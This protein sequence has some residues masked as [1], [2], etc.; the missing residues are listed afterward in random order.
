MIGHHLKG[1][2]ITL[3]SRIPKDKCISF[4]FLPPFCLNAEHSFEDG[5]YT[6]FLAFNRKGIQSYVRMGFL[7]R[8]VWSVVSKQIVYREGVVHH[9]LEFV[10]MPL[11]MGY[12]VE[13]QVTGTEVC[14]M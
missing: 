9:T 10:A 6:S 7:W 1:G 13:G 5:L 2:K 12:T 3:R 14:G 11:G 4:L 8:L